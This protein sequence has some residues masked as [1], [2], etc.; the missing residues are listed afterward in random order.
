[1]VDHPL[2]ICLDDAGRMNQNGLIVLDSRIGLGGVL[3]GDLH[4]ETGNQRPADIGVVVLVVE[5]G[6][7]QLDAV[8]FHDALELRTYVIRA[9]KM[10]QGA[11]VLVAPHLHIGVPAH[12]ALES[13]VQVQKGQMVAIGVRELRLHLVG[14]LS[15]RV[16]PNPWRRYGQEGDDGQDLVASV[17]FRTTDEHHGQL[18][19]EGKFG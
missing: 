13:V 16:R 10:P 17:E 18:W 3:H 8:R 2:V 11:K 5:V 14:T 12:L 1:M 19:I 15:L 7:Q 9:L 4:E 6:A